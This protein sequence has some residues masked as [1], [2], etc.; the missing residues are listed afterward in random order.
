[1][2]APNNKH[3]HL[4]ETFPCSP[5]TP[6]PK[7]IPLPRRTQTLARVQKSGCID[8]ATTAAPPRAVAEPRKR[9]ES[10]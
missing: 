8:V 4:P 5:S 1:V 2:Y 6:P 9:K 10:T 7:T 3:T